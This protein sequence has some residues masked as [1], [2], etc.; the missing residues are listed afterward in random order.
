M[1][2]RLLY[3]VTHAM[4]V[5][6]LLRGQLAHMQDRGFK[7]AVACGGDFDVAQLE[8]DAHVRVLHV[9]LVREIS[10]THDLQALAALRRLMLE[11]R[12]DIVNAGTP[13]AGLLGMLAARMAGVPIR[14]YTLRGLRLETTRGATRVILWASERVAAAAAH[15][16]LAVSE[17]L[18]ETYLSSRLAAAPKV[19]VLGSGASNGVDMKRFTAPSMETVASLRR[20]IGMPD[21]GEVI[22]FVG[23]LTR[24]KGIAELLTAFERVRQRRPQTRLLVVGALEAGDALSEDTVKRLADLP[25]V[26]TTGHLEDPASAY[27]LMDLLAFPSHREGFPN[28]VLEAAAAGLPVVGYDVTGTRDAVSSGT[29][30]VLVARGDAE[31]MADALSVYLASPH[32]RASHGEAARSRVSNSFTNE[33]VWGNLARLYTRLL[34][35]RA[36]PAPAAYAPRTAENTHSSA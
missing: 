23:R 4:T 15:K 12:P 30:G 29:T 21:E 5:R 13:K 18:R 11:W 7:V 20:R 6:Q 36:L 22:G 14:L 35:Q 3:V 31:A 8:R 24:D 9:P 28:V 2:P 17:S 19:V 10:L 33:V 27:S 32:L 26:H 16:V 34:E 25:G 1:K